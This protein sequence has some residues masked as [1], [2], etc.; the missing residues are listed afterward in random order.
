M[1]S[2][3]KLL[4]ARQIKVSSLKYILGEDGSPMVKDSK[5]NASQVIGIQFRIM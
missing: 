1:K 5:T 2:K 3:I 4:L